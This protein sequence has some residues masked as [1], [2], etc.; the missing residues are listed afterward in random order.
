MGNLGVCYPLADCGPTE[1]EPK[2]ENQMF[3]DEKTLEEFKEFWDDN[4]NAALPKRDIYQMC[5]SIFRSLCIADD[6]D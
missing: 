6:V 2:G 3:I 4:V 1:A 5:V